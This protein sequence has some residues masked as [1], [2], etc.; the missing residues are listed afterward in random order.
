MKL[1]ILPALLAAQA[2]SVL[3]K[4]VVS[5]ERRADVK[6]Q[7]K[8]EFDRETTSFK[9]SGLCR[10]YNKATWKTHDGITLTCTPKCGDLAKA[11]KDTGKTQSAGCLGNGDTLPYQPDPDGD[12]FQMGK[13]I[14]DMP[15]A[16]E[17][18]D[19]V[20][21]ALPA[22]AQIGCEI[23][24]KSLD[25]VLELG[26]MAIPG[27]A[28]MDVGMRAAITGAK[29]MLENGQDAS[30]FLQW[31]LH[32]CGAASKYT[33]DIDKIFDPL[34]AVSDSIVK[35]NGK[36]KPAPG[37]KDDGKKPTSI[38]KPPV[39]AVKTTAPAK[40]AEQ[41]KTTAKPT[42]AN[43]TSH[44]SSHASSLTSS[45][46]SSSAKQ[47]FVKASKPATKPTNAASSTTH[48]AGA[49]EETEKTPPEFLT[50]LISSMLTANA[51]SMTTSTTAA[52]IPTLV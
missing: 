10:Y 30:T 6:K 31:I 37:K 29:T 21:E 19:L 41:P 20:I 44:T 33:E 13:C 35:G 22:I 3:A 25:L 11:V 49:P 27:A 42:S 15:L 23:L 39:S 50:S 28:E 4:P 38:V 24:F 52:V 47:T 12:M 8:T 46:S 14:C 9:G 48:T 17:I 51:T 18:A 45:R 1:W 7:D 40:T 26:A 5:V 43:P 2:C 16:D 34:S 32:P 36:G